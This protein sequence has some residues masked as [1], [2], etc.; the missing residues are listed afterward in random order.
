LKQK[1]IAKSG[2]KIDMGKVER[3]AMALQK[4]IDD[5]EIAEGVL[6]LKLAPTLDAKVALAIWQKNKARR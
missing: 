1:E 3:M 6:N 2:R 4:L 5:V